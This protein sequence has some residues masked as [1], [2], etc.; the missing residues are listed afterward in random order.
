MY[1]KTYCDYCGE[2]TIVGEETCQYFT[3]LITIPTGEQEQSQVEMKICEDC[4]QSLEATTDETGQH[5]MV[6]VLSSSDDQESGN[7]SDCAHS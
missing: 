7:R 5:L 4:K 2:G 1:A 3:V 6:T